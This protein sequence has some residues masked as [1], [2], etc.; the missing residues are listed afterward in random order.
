MYFDRFDICEA[1]WMYYCLWHNG[2]L[3]RRCRKRNADTGKLNRG[4]AVQLSRMRFKPAPSLDLDSLSDNG[5][6]IYEALVQK[7]EGTTD[8][9]KRDEGE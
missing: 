7:H 3:T 8:P 1:Y 9:I 4:I 5:K 2:G 6:D